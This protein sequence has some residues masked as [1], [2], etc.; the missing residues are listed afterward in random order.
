MFFL[1]DLYAGKVR[2]TLNLV[3]VCI[4]RYY[5]QSLLSWSKRLSTQ[6]KYFSK[7]DFK[8]Y[9]ISV[10]NTV[11]K[12]NCCRLQ[13]MFSPTEENI[14]FTFSIFWKLS[15]SLEAARILICLL[16]SLIQSLSKS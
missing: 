14:S 12:I 2:D 5:L 6:M 3:S 11:S 7:L 16:Y 13:A 15:C 4:P 10:R 8:F 9:K 1:R